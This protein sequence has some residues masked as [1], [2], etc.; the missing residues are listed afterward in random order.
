MTLKNKFKNIIE[1]H[2]SPMDYYDI[3]SISE[4]SI[5]LSYEFAIGFA[6]WLLLNQ[7][8]EIDFEDDDDPK[9]VMEKLLQIYNEEK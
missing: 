7:D 1:D 9:K 4:R 2:D 3:D 8:L 5:Q 6:L